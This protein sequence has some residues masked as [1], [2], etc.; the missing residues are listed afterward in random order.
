[1]IDPVSRWLHKGAG[2]HGPVMLMYHSVLPGTGSP[3]WPWA[4]SLAR[5]RAQLDFLAGEG[6]ATPTVSELLSR[7]DAYTGRT[8]VITFDDGYLDNLMAWQ[9]LSKRNM[10]ATWYVV[11]GSLGR[12]PAW[13]ADGR[14]P[15]RLLNIQE[16]REMDASGMEIGSHTE[17]HVK[18]PHADDE[19]L[20]RELLD[21]KQRLEDLLHR[22]VHTFAYPHGAWNERCERAVKDA[23]YGSACTTRTGWALRDDDPYR[24]RR[25]TVTHLDNAASLARMCAF[26]DNRVAWADV[27]RYGTARLHARV[28]PAHG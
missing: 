8:A 14:P 2:G 25:L 3:V 6:Y 23:G 17:H 7:S 5:F 19:T 16:L 26:A 28:R 12:E 21:S 27:L 1:M 24:L 4:I 9:E 22:P 20:Q 15:G 18:L 10:R 11:T 13:P